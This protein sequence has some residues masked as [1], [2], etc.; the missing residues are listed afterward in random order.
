MGLNNRSF[1][2]RLTHWRFFFIVNIVIIV[3]LAMALG[4]EVA[5]SRSIDADIRKL[6]VR[7][8]ALS[9]RNAEIFALQ[10]A[11]GTE[12]Y[13]EREARLKLGLKKPGETVVIIKDALPQTQPDDSVANP[14][15]PFGYVIGER[16]IPSD[17]VANPY[18]WWYYF[19]DK[20]KFDQTSRL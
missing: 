9:V 11:F 17:G 2:Y 19:F 15:D 8:D 14:A 4:R 6:Q 5:R 13:I 12:S 3:F 7:I 1:F 18:K 16:G 20:K 10:N